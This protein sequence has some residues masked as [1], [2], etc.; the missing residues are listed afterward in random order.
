MFSEKNLNECT[1]GSERPEFTVVLK[2][3][4]GVDKNGF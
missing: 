2:D 1:N 4:L 3:N